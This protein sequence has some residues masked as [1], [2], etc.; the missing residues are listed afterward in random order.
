MQAGAIMD[1]V[2]RMKLQGLREKIVQ[3]VDVEDVFNY[4]I[5]KGVLSVEDM[6][7]I[8]AEKTRKDRARHLLDILLGKNGSAFEH[9]VESLKKTYPWLS[10]QIEAEGPQSYQVE[11]KSYFDTLL[12]GGLP[13]PPPH[14]VERKEKMEEVRQHLHSLQRGRYVVLHGMTGSGK[15]CLAAAALDNKQL[16]IEK[17]KGAVYWIGVGDISSESSDDLLCHMTDL[18]EKLSHHPS[19]ESEKHVQSS[20][21]VKGARE[22]LRRYFTSG[23]LRDGLL[24]LDDVYSPVVIDAFDIGCKILVTTKDSKVM[25]NVQ[26]RHHLIR[27]SEGFS[28]QESLCL[29]AECAGVEISHL[30]PAAK[31]I[32]QFSKGVPM[33]IALIG[34]QL[35]ENK[36]DVQRNPGRWEF[37]LDKLTRHDYGNI[38]KSV[39]LQDAIG[40]CVNTLPDDMKCFYQDFALFVEDV[41]IRPEV[42]ETL[43]SKNKYEVEDIMSEFIKKS[44]AVSKW[45]ELLNSYV[46]G[47]HDLLLHYLKNQLEK[48][49]KKELHRKLLNCYKSVSGSSFSNLP[50]DN[51]IYSYIGYHLYEAELWSMFPKLYLDLE[52]IGSKLKVTGPGDLLVDYKKYSKYI[53]A[54]DEQLD[55]V[56]QQIEQFIQL[57]GL[58]IHK[59]QDTDIVQFA[60]QEARSS[61]I[62]KEALKIAKARPNKLYLEFL[63][64]QHIVSQPQTLSVKE[65]VFAACFTSKENQI[66][67]ANG[68]GIINLWDRDYAHILCTFPGHKGRISHLAL[69]PD[70]TQFLSCS[71]D[72]TVKLWNLEGAICCSVKTPSPRT[73][74]DNWSN[75]FSSDT[76]CDKSF[77]TFTGH[78]SHVLYATFSHD[79]TEVMSCS[80]DGSVKI[81]ECESGVLRLTLQSSTVTGFARCCMYT[82]VGGIVIFGGEDKML[83]FYDSNAGEPIANCKTSGCVIAVLSVAHC[84]I[85]VV[86]DKSISICTWDEEDN[87][88]S[89]L[90]AEVL[91][92]ELSLSPD[93]KNKKQVR[94]FSTRSSAVIKNFKCEEFGQ[95]SCANYTCAILSQDDQYIIVGA[96]NFSISVWDV[97]E[98]TLVKEYQDHTGQVRCLDTFCGSSYQ[99]LLSGSDDKTIK[100]WHIELAEKEQENKLKPTYDAL[101]DGNS[102]DPC[103]PLLAARDDCN[104]LQ[105]LRGR[106]VVTETTP[107]SIEVKTCK[108]STCGQYLVYGCCDGSVKLF[109]IKNKSTKVIMKLNGC[110][111]YL[112]VSYSSEVM[113]VAAAEDNSLKIWKGNPDEKGTVVTCAGQTAKV[114][115]CFL[116]SMHQK[117]LSCARDGSVKVWETAT[118][119]LL[120]VVIGRHVKA[121]VN[122]ADL[123]QNED[124]LVLCDDSG[125]FLLVHFSI[126]SQPQRVKIQN[127]NTV[128]LDDSLCSCKLSHDAQ[129]LALGQ[130]NGNIIIWDVNNAVVLGT[131][132]LHKTSV[133][134]LL[135]S[136]PAK[137][138][139]S[140]NISQPPLILL[141]VGDQIGWWDVNQ[142][143]TSCGQ[144][145][146]M[147]SGQQ[148]RRRR[149]GDSPKLA[150]KPVGFSALNGSVGT[151]HLTDEWLGKVGHKGK[152]ELLGCVKL[153]GREAKNISA[154]RNFTAFAT[155]DASGFVYLLKIFQ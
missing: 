81:W 140:L 96:S 57:H 54:D 16:L 61:H 132:K 112:Q 99:L 72:A 138:D 86:T 130:A 13:Q 37:Y 28:E 85:A 82:D 92:E 43:W 68:N 79:G 127:N 60:L 118:G 115:Q 2:R 6:E 123:S 78:T 5:S 129:L 3:D 27:I 108:L 59:Y 46:Y 87:E 153:V 128:F 11:E 47:I 119:E 48:E 109:D 124:L 90:N 69:S 76:G 21:S 126:L 75:M 100:I 152:P 144:R 64:H 62:Y 31:K 50:N 155:I 29:M 38:N 4:L 53:I 80:R 103:I 58:D 136:P 131:L 106:S 116:M 145:R 56:L 9:F 142:L 95:C 66:L 24:I 77:Q 98:H 12:L 55:L 63:L 113:A 34:A 49:K 114:V 7:L 30:P 44:L 36:D 147:S 141:S 102:S 41:N 33:V 14:N 121:K 22:S 89:T 107:E 93:L 146:R 70:E 125:S 133:R 150:V 17:F 35:A 51:Y 84:E 39:S 83:S 101:W 120:D 73:R 137:A 149:S 20:T 40:L 139:G 111:H 52:F 15:S 97:D 26:G 1:T 88:F 23:A 10:K 67:T 71:E 110:V 74:Q 104:K 45:N 154:S 117:L 91:I 94:T 151:E 25:K 19:V 32:H 8:K 143:K 148:R 122:M 105:L 135:F 134:N 65:E 42:L 18:L